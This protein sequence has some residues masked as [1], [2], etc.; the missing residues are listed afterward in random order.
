MSKNPVQFQEGYSL[1][2]LFEDYGNEEQ[3]TEAL[4]RWKWPEGFVCPECGSSKY[5]TLKSRKVYQCNHLYIFLL[6]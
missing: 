5:C 4:F 1:I 6:T 3:C 2:E